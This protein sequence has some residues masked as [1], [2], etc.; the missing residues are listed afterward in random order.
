MISGR[1]KAFALFGSPVE[2]S[3]SPAMHNA[4]FAELGLDCVYLCH[5][6]VPSAIGAAVAGARAMGFAG[7]NVT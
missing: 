3:L 2:H 7:F 4:S 6:V 1:T 5:D